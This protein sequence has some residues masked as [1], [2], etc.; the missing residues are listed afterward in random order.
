MSL[1]IRFAAAGL[2]FIN[3]L[4]YT[5]FASFGAEFCIGFSLLRLMV[6][7]LRRITQ[8]RRRLPS[9][10]FSMQ[11]GLV[12][13]DLPTRVA[14]HQATKGMMFGCVF[15]VDEDECSSGVN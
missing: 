3:Y 14:A 6:G 1:R 5:F 13:C 9:T 7:W 4:I 8:R 11:P 2:P 12:S 15:S 10:P